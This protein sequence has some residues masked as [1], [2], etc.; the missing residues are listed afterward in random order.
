MKFNF[1]SFFSIS[2]MVLKMLETVRTV[3]AIFLLGGP[4]LELHIGFIYFSIPCWR[5]MGE[6]ATPSNTQKHKTLQLLFS[7]GK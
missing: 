3:H 6:G 2:N 7:G 4:V 5:L 1:T